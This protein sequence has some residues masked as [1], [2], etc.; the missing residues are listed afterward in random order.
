MA[1]IGKKVK[2]IEIPDDGEKEIPIPLPDNWPL[3]LPVPVEEPI[4]TSG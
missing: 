3:P 4:K 1:D 2:I